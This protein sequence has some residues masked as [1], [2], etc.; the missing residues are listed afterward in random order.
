[1]LL[2]IEVITKFS[3]YKLICRELYIRKFS[4][5]ESP[6]IV[7][8]SNMGPRVTRLDTVVGEKFGTGIEYCKASVLYLKQCGNIAVGTQIR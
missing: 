4:L 5:R 8:R 6:W 3:L 2:I 1:M 7:K